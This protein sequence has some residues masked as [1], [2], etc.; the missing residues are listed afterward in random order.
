[1]RTI[2][3]KGD[4]KNGD[5]LYYNSENGNFCISDGAN[6]YVYGVGDTEFE[7]DTLDKFK[8]EAS[9]SI[10]YYKNTTVTT[11][12]DGTVTVTGTPFKRK[13]G[14]ESAKPI[15]GAPEESVTVDPIAHDW[16]TSADGTYDECTICHKIRQ[17]E[18]PD[19][20]EEDSGDTN[21]AMEL[22]V[23]D[24]DGL[25]VPFTV[26]QEGTVRT[27]TGNYDV[28]TLTGSLATLKYLQEHGAETIVF[29]TNQHTSTFNINDVLAQ[30]GDSATLY[31]THTGTEAQLLVVE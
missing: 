13:T 31:L 10:T 22:R 17:R 12:E 3:G 6:L 11:N 2:G 18:K 29:V 19:T 28:A 20:S 4:T 5:S 24:V 8:P 30:G 21:S 14:S 25:D 23:T 7:L 16:V 1:M 15:T 9:G 27:Y 26:N